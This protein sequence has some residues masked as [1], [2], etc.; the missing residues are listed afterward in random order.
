M[1]KLHSARPLWVLIAAVLIVAL[2]GCSSTISPGKLFGRGK[3]KVK[4]NAPP[5]CPSISILADAATLTRF[6]RPGTT[7][8]TDTLYDAQIL[9]V[10]IKCKVEG[11]VVRTEFGVSG[12]ITLGP[13][14]TPGQTDL[15]IFAALTL[16]DQDVLRKITRDSSVTIKAGKRTANFIEIVKR[17]EFRL[18]A[19][20]A[21]TD[22]EILTGFNLTPAQ[23]KYN[24]RYQ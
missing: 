24:Q 14:G 11:G 4:T 5:N 20:K 17:F 6:A 3:A 22:Y 9:K 21:A 7:D 10:A 16:K 15:P 19:G 12:S 23:V 2:A 8:I 1:T 18:A 13:S